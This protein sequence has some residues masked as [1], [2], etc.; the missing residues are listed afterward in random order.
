MGSPPRSPALSSALSNMSALLARARSVLDEAE[1]AES[2][3]DRF[4]LAHLAALR[5]AAVVIAE[6]GRPAGSR[7]RLVSAPHERGKRVG[8]DI[9]HRHIGARG[10][11]RNRKR[12]AASATVEDRRRCT[13]CRDRLERLRKQLPQQCLPSDGAIC[14]LGLHDG[15]SIPRD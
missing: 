15:Q 6:R 8:T 12:A 14:G 9:D 2:P 7:R 3:A 1:R 5:T 10:R 11:E 13:C 4:C